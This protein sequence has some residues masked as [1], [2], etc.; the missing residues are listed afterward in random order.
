[1]IL[2]TGKTRG[3]VITGSPLELLRASRWPGTVYREAEGVVRLPENVSSWKLLRDQDFDDVTDKAQA[4]LNHIGEKY[5]ES[6]RNLKI[7]TRKFK[8]TGET[9]IP[10]PLRSVPYE[11]QVRGYGFCSQVP[12]SGLFADQG[13]G[14]SLMAIAVAGRR[15]LDGEVT[16]VVVVSPKT[17]K[18][19]WPRELRSHAGY[20]WSASV[21]K[22]P[23]TGDGCLFWVMSYGEVKGLT[24]EIRKWKPEMII[25]DESHRLKNRDTKTFKSFRDACVKIPYRLLLT[26]TPIGKC[27]SEAWSQFNIIDKDLFGSFSSFKDRYLV[28]GG[29]M[30]YSVVGYKN[31][32]E[33]YDKFHSL[34]FRVTKDECLDLPP[35]SYQRIYVE[36]SQKLR[37]QYDHFAQQLFLD[38]K[39]GEVTAPGQ[40]VAQMKLRQIA[41]GTVKT[42]DGILSK[43]SSV[44]VSALREFLEDRLNDKT[45][46][47]FSF[48]HEMDA[49]EKVCKN[50]GIKY[51]R[52]SGSTPQGQRD[53]FESRFQGHRGPCVA[54][55][56]C[57]TGAEGLTLHS[58]NYALFYSPSFSYV[59]YAQAR[60]RINRIGQK[61][62]VTIGFLIVENTMDERVVEVLE[63]NGQLVT[64]TLDDNRQYKLRKQIMAKKP[65]AKAATETKTT[66][67]TEGY[68]AAA[69]AEEF[70]LAP[71]DLRKHL[72]ALKIEKPEAGWV[73]PKKTDAGLVEIRKALKERLKSLEAKAA[74]KTEAPAKAKAAPKAKAK[75]E[76]KAP[77]KGKKASATKAKKAS[78]A[79]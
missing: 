37:E 75:T 11:H 22:K 8:T 14:K 51:L 23:P 47:F 68:N 3:F 10:V 7:A 72:R 54:I 26:G 45:I 21:N 63:S 9:D 61:R 25:A 57:T 5:R 24:K 73:W 4:S 62:A 15:Y 78:A 6:R 79:E 38:T 44:K 59:A 40:A 33:F 31:E 71:A 48:V 70:E 12:S 74:G 66:A 29:Y 18:S 64:T 56:Q 60:D 55:I 20:E 53:T 76:E 58:A 30:N 28:M 16:R 27:I 41:G 2:G 1:M 65:A 43:I 17:V 32:A 34:S 49:A 67:K 69:L 42:D 19:V 52:L 13:T 50:L 35:V 39:N 46:V 36:A 77:A